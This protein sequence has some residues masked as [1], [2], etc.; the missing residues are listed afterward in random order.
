MNIHDR[1]LTPWGGV[2]LLTWIF[3]KTVFGNMWMG[4][5]SHAK[6]RR[7]IGCSLKAARIL[8]AVLIAPEKGHDPCLS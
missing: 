1:K 3:V 2:Y 8:E 7:R 5:L 6:D 4:V